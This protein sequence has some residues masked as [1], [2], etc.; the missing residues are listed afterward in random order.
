MITSDIIIK[1]L[2]RNNVKEL[3]GIPGNQILPLY[4]S[5][6]KSKIKH[7]LTRHEQGAVH[8]ADGYA[9]SS[10]K[11]GTCIS[12][13]GPGAMNLVM[14]IATAFKDSVPLLVIT[15]DN[16]YPINYNNF[17]SIKVNDVFKS[18]TV[19]SFYPKDGETAIK[20]LE[21]A[22]KILKYG[23]SGPVHI[24]FPKNVL[25][26]D[27]TYNLTD[28]SNNY[29]YENL[30]VIK[31]RLNKSERPLILAGGG[32]NWSNCEKE[33]EDFVTKNNIPIVTTFHGK[34][35]IS[36]FNSMN[37]G[38]VGI[39]GSDISEY[40]ILNSDL[41]LCLGCKLSER[42]TGNIV[43]L[44]E[45]KSKLISINTNETHL[46]GLS[47]KITVKEFLKILKDVEFRKSSA[48]I[49]E[50][51]TN[52]QKLIID[53]IDDDSLPLRPPFIIN[54]ILENRDGAT[55]ISDAGSHTTWTFLLTKNSEPRKLLF[56]GGFGPMGYGVP[57]GIGA[58]IA[59]PK[60]KIFVINGDGDF[61]MNLQELS[62]I[63][64]NNLNICIFILNNSQLGIIKQWEKI[65][66]IPPYQ[67]DLNS[68]PNFVKLGE[69]YNIKSFKVINK[70]ELD[71][72]LGYVNSFKGPCI[73]EILT[74]EE[75][76]P[77]P[78]QLF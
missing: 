31:N 53:G 72:A 19:K 23:P 43:D 11:F 44:N 7:I 57:A 3:F 74:R 46:K 29:S 18:I 27:I 16:D 68:N 17:Q 70:E 10:G 45:F 21:E 47:M 24:N 71:Y 30:E 42:T 59:N 65:N 28:I 69:S 78:S 9:R 25:S 50:I 12:T 8:A 77:L 1:I 63:K 75:D 15:G 5:L 73:V 39:R 51:Y 52:N 32:V 26:E 49:D 60:D 48:W 20:N 76:I 40:A 67:V 64:E 58:S 66:D 61:Q 6:R 54:K 55:I 62:T 2:E 37:L 22:I 35:V 4:D 41:I 33:L 38:I 34:G 36:E 14:G 13:A 56:S